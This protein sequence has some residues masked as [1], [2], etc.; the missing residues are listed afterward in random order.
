M[1]A[2]CTFTIDS[3]EEVVRTCLGSGR[4]HSALRRVAGQCVKGATG[5][6]RQGRICLILLEGRT[7]GTG[8]GILQ[9]DHR[10][11]NR[12]RLQETC[13]PRLV[14]RK[15]CLLEVRLER[16]LGALQLLKRHLRLPLKD[17][18]RHSSSS[19]VSWHR[20]TSPS[21]RRNLSHAVCSSICSI[22]PVACRI[23]QNGG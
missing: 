4:V 14:N 20:K 11:G 6:V 2:R 16:E 17:W 13:R 15:S 5:V 18:S 23:S 3:E 12:H 9:L 21:M 19:R 1:V 10:V 7:K 22:A 8:K